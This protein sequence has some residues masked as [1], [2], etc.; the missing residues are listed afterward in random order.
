MGWD[1]SNRSD[2]DPANE[3]VPFTPHHQ[4]TEP[5]KTTTT[6][7]PERDIRDPAPTVAVPFRVIQRGRQSGQRQSASTATA[8]DNISNVEAQTTTADNWDQP[9]SDD[10]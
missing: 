5:A 10:W 8:E 6:A 7:W 3:Q 1:R 9:L 4:S 2:W